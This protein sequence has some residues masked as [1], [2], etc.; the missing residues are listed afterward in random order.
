M[1]AVVFF[2]QYWIDPR[3]VYGSSLGIPKM[4]ISGNI[5]EQ[6]WLPDTYFVNDLSEQ[7]IMDDYFFE[8]SEE[9]RII[10]SYRYFMGKMLLLHLD[11]IPVVFDVN[12]SEL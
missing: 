3:L 7:K 8:L 2:R 1:S 5:V 11:H 9:G 4:K 12:D 10:Y 6:V